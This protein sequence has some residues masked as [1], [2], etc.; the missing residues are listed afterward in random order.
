VIKKVRNEPEAEEE[1]LA[2]AR[3]YDEKRPGLGDEFLAAVDAAVE[4]IQSHPAGGRRAPG[5]RKT[6][7]ARRILLRRFPYAVVYL[8]LE[9]ELR[10]L[11]FAHERRRPGY[12]K[13]RLRR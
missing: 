13:R 9:R 6:V 8:E 7:P 12:W 2:A 4:L 11:A 1:L 5:V 10:I 3:W